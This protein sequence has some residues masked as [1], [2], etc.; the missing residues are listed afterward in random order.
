VSADV[1]S[2]DVRSP[3]VKSPFAVAL[4][5]AVRQPAFL[6][7]ALV[8]LVAAVSLN[9]ATEFLQLH[10][11]KEKVDLRKKLTEI[12]ARLGPWEQATT[13]MAIT[14]EIEDV[15]GTKDYIYRFYVD[16][17]RVSPDVIAQ[18]KDKD[19]RTQ[20]E[21]I[22][23][24]Q[25]RDPHAVVYCAVTYYSGM[26]DTV[27]HIPDR[28]YVADGYEPASYDVVHWSSLQGRPGG[29]AGHGTARYINFEDQTPSRKSVTKN[30]AYFFHS[31]GE[32][33]NDPQDVRRKLQNL[34]ETHGYYAKVELLMVTGDRQGAAGQ[35]NDFLTSALPELEG[36]LPDWKQVK[37]AAKATKT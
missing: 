12:P 34:F 7:V 14:H 10:F 27:A 6:T 8:L 22:S 11:K 35:M 25:S 5:R 13:D 33:T 29:G 21:M 20:R 3:D 24:L 23:V 26:V 31:N 1:K 37:A 17:R 36:C 16:T 15:L 32:Y 19:E 18:F 9:G 2:S 30:V 28:C 4:R